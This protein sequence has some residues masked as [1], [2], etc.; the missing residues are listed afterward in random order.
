MV[1][2]ALVASTAAQ[3]QIYVAD[4]APVVVAPPAPVVVVPPPVVVAPQAPVVVAPG[5]A[6][7]AYVPAPSTTVVNPR[8]G[9]TC[10]I[11]PNGYHWCWTP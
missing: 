11:Q 8:N 1:A 4:P 5:Y 7:Y 9:R 6:D 2:V 3:A 10:T